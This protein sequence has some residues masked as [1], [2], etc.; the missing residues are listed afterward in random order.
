VFKSYRLA[1][2]Q[3]PVERKNARNGLPMTHFLMQKPY[4]KNIYHFLILLNH[5]EN[6]GRP[7]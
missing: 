4:A 1:S 3:V 5:S 7:M 6:T 2:E